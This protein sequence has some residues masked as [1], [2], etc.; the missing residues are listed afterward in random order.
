MIDR[1]SDLPDFSSPP[2]TEVVLGVQ[3]NSL[4]GFLA[5]HV[6]L[7]W[8]ALPLVFGHVEEHLPI[9]PM[10]ETFG[11]NPHLMSGLDFGLPPFSGLSRTFFLNEDRTQLLQLQRDRL[12]HNWRKVGDGDSYP[13][14]EAML[15]T[16]LT[17]LKLFSLFVSEKGLGVIEPNQCEVSYINQIPLQH[18]ETPFQGIERLFGRALAAPS[19]HT[20]GP[21]EDARL[22]LRY[23]IRN[24]SGAPVGRLIIAAD[25]ARRA[26]GT[27][28]IQLNLTARGRP[29]DL[30]TDAVDDFLC[31]GRIFIVHTFADITS[32]EMHRVWGRKK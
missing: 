14:F 25:P 15:S 16:F 18:G 21:P 6:G 31:R 3:F 24:E 9:A 5:P 20:P 8:S 29:S 26:D 17:S 13:R 19:T 1:P 10:F 27:H 28:I 30:S 2:V 11:Q 7:F 32:P 4:D 22:L 12:I 23:V